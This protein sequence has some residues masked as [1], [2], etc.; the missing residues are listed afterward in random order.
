MPDPTLKQIEVVRDDF[1]RSRITGQPLPNLA[2]GQVLARI[3]TFALTANNVSYA[4]SG[5]MLGYWR[6]FPCPEPWGVLPVWGFATVVRSRCEALP[7]GERFWG[8]LPMASHVVL[9]P[10]EVRARGFADVAAHRQGL[11]DV[12]NRYQ[13]TRTDPPELS[14]LEAE[15]SALVPLFTTSFMI[16]DFLADNDWFGARQLLVLSASSKTGFGLADLAGRRDGRPVRV[17]GATSTGNRGFVEAL[18]VCDQVVSYDEIETLDPQVPTVV[19]DLAGASEVRARVHGHFR[20]HLTHSCI[21]GVTHW[22]KRGRRDDLPGPKPA[23]FFGP[24]QA[25]KRDQDW[26]PGVMRQRAQVEALR[27]A[28]ETASLRTVETIAGA[29]GCQRAWT[30]LLA[31]RVGPERVLMLSFHE[32][33][34]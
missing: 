16:D 15:R 5:D 10:G 31:G 33:N 12:Y 1:A 30:E 26:G 29:E 17:V 7:E 19:V 3:E 2:P 27:I 11:A 21:V 23:F 8:F 28:R 4:V 22:D 34:G 32:H 9:E 13:L 6:F 18:G 25:A 20:D 14:G 24:G